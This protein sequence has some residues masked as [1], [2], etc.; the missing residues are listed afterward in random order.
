VTLASVNHT[1][2]SS[3]TAAPTTGAAPTVLLFGHGRVTLARVVK[4]GG[5]HYLL[6]KVASKA[7]KVRVRLT[8]LARNGAIVRRRTMLVSAGS[9]HLVKIP[10]TSA[11][12]SVKVTVVS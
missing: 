5:Q 11:V 9:R 2:A 10:Y 7:K 3:G 6:L 8:E 4:R 12:R 1:G